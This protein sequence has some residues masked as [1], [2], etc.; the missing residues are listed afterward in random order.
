MQLRMRVA[1]LFGLLGVAV[2]VQAAVQRHMS[3]SALPT[4]KVHSQR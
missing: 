4:V 2:G 1:I 3:S